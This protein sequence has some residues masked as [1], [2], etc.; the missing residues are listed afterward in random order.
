[1]HTSIVVARTSS[2]CIYQKENKHLGSFLAKPRRARTEEQKRKKRNEKNLYGTVDSHTRIS[3]TARHV[4]ASSSSKLGGQALA[5]AAARRCREV[6]AVAYFLPPPPPTCC[7]SVQGYKLH[8]AWTRQD[9]TVRAVAT[10]REPLSAPH[11]NSSS[12]P[13]DNARNYTRQKGIH[14]SF[15]ERKKE[16]ERKKSSWTVCGS[17][18]QTPVL[19]GIINWADEGFFFSFI[20]QVS[21]LRSCCVLFFFAWGREG[22]GGGKFF[23]GFL[24]ILLV[25]ACR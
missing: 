11:Q 7:C 21:G 5:V 12:P 18:E 16:R 19:A 20:L 17:A 4:G 9:R 2:A 15:Q 1:M 25:Y 24:I 3:T 14:H 13:A 6:R 22:R 8:R 23:N 10:R